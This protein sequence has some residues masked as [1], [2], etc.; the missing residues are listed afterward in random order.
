MLRFWKEASRQTLQRS[1][2]GNLEK[3]VKA[4]G[5]SLVTWGPFEAVVCSLPKVAVEGCPSGTE[6]LR[7]TCF[8][9]G[10]IEEGGSLM[11]GTAAELLYMIV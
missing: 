9:V 3:Q 4:A 11:A 2:G 8:E 6:A 7:R 10:W 5:G 1:S